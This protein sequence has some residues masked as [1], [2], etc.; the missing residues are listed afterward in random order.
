MSNEFK[1]KVVFITGASTGIGRATAQMFARL[2]AKVAVADVAIKPGEETVAELKAKG[3]EA[4]FLKCDVSSEKQII[5]SLQATIKKYGR[6]DYAFNNAG[7]EG[8][9]ASTEVCTNENWD[10]TI[11]INLRGV[12]WCMKHEIAQM[13]KQGGGA[14][15]NCS[16]IAGTVGFA[17]LPAYV[18]SKHGVIGLTKTAA[19]EFATKNIRVN[20][21]CPGVIQTPMIDR[22][23]KGDPA[24][25]E[26]FAKSAP[27]ERVGNPEEIATT[28]KWLFSSDSSFVT[29]QAIVVDGGWT[30][31]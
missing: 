21:V 22:F 19:L 26:G 6:I 18:A 13:L 20:A 15:V 31:K 16:S 3:G 9:P 10:H 8:S 30:V 7:V 24:A 14:I 5:E 11:N 25:L 2:G 4:I 12:W 23:T 29:G 27:M 17:N 28:V 1:D